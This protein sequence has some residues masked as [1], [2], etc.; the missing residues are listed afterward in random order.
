MVHVREARKRA[1]DMEAAYLANSAL[2]ISR[3][4]KLHAPE[5]DAEEHKQQTLAY[6]AVLLRHVSCRNPDALIRPVRALF[7]DQEHGFPLQQS[8]EMTQE[9]ACFNCTRVLS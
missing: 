1:T 9:S 3:L 5:M 4:L 7:D 8:I 2:D 6:R